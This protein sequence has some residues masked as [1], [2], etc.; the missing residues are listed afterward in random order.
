MN[1]IMN[2]I[3]KRSLLYLALSTFVFVIVIP[4]Q[5]Q[6]KTR[7]H[8]T[9]TTTRDHSTTTR[10]H[11]T[12]Y[13][14]R[15]HRNMGATPDN[16]SPTS[17]KK[18]QFLSFDEADALFGKRTTVVGKYPSFKYTGKMDTIML[19]PKLQEGDNLIYKMQTGNT[20]HVWVSKGRI[21]ELK[22]ND[23]SQKEIRADLFQNEVVNVE[24]RPAQVC[25]N[26]REICVDEIDEA[27]S[28]TGGRF[29]W[30]Q[31]IKVECSSDHNAVL[32]P[33]VVKGD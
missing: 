17:D 10:D 8:R 28:F 6:S 12:K 3:L 25:L 15:D 30:S 33:V 26:C 5:A 9:K 11:R 22:L 20:L 32:A 4:L 31:C 21:V 27:G 7:D 23:A 14:I 19:T 1:T 13:K 29:C 2:S 24:K 16:T 18:D